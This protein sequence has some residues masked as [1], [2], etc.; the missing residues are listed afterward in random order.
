MVAARVNY[1]E[2]ARFMARSDQPDGTRS[3]GYERVSGFRRKP[4]RS[5][6]SRLACRPEFHDL[7]G[8]LRVDDFHAVQHSLLLV[9]P[10]LARLMDQMVQPIESHLS[11]VV[12]GIVDDT[13]Q[14]Q[15]FRLDV[16]ANGQP[17]HFYFRLFGPELLGEFVQRLAPLGPFKFPCRHDI[18]LD[19]GLQIV[20]NSQQLVRKIRD[21]GLR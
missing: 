3:V 9:D 6:W 11:H 17:Y 5:P 20:A 1:D 16:V 21:G 12:L 8:A 15:P 19:Q 18:I 14:W 7:F 4:P 13:D 2:R 10:D